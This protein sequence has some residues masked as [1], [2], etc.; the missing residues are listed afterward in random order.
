MW[1]HNKE[2]DQPLSA[3]NQHISAETS[4]ETKPL[5]TTLIIHHEN[6]E[7]KNRFTNSIRICG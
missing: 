3:K 5:S 2:F 1:N 7:N 6:I 4:V